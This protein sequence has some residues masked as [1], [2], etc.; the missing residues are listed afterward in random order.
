MVK[1][2]KG[3][4]GIFD[5]MMVKALRLD[6]IPTSKDTIRQRTRGTIQPTV[7]TSILR[8]KHNELVVGIAQTVISTA[9]MAEIHLKK[10]GRIEKE[11]EFEDLLRYRISR[12]STFK[13]FMKEMLT[14]YYLKSNAYALIVR[15][16]GLGMGSVKRLQ[17]ISP[18]QVEV[19]Q[20]PDTDEILYKIDGV[21]GVVHSHNM[22]HLKG[23]T[24]DGLKGMDMGENTSNTTKLGSSL[25]G[26]LYNKLEK[27]TIPF[28]LKSKV[29]MAYD[30]EDPEKTAIYESYMMMIDSYLKGE[31]PLMIDERVM[32]IEELNENPHYFEL[33]KIEKVLKSRL[34]NIFNIPYGMIDATSGYDGYEDIYRVFVNQ[35][36]APILMMFSDEFTRKLLTPTERSEGYTI[37]FDMMTIFKTD[38]RTLSSAIRDLLRGGVMSQNEGRAH[39]GMESVEKGDQLYVSKDLAPIDM[40]LLDISEEEE[41]LIREHRA[42]KNKKESKIPE[43]KKGE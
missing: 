4:R 25:D 24:L 5:E 12:G 27:K 43:N 29:D 2:K 17:M 10:N 19:E 21:K 26:S 23:M 15:D 18:E 34:S 33:D 36:I 22:I 11:N 32:G 37:E 40:I 1:E 20:D 28:A 9:T 39:L 41:E 6:E 7:P 13:G 14:N 16:D 8:S 35:T 31:A 42:T 38:I 3:I 30:E